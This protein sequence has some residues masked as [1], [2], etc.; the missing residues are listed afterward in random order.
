MQKKNLFV[1]LKED[2]GARAIALTVTIML[3]V[4][5]AIIVTT[6]VAN[7]AANNDNLPPDD[8]QQAGVNDPNTDENPNGTP[9]QTPDETPGDSTQKPDDSQTGTDALPERFLLPVSGVMQQ[10]HDSALQVFSPTMG[11]Y[12]VHLGID[13]GTVEGASVSAMADGTIAQVWEDV[14]M[15]QC[16]AVKHGGDAYTVYKNLSVE[17]PETTVV[18][19]T[20]KA[21]DVIGT[22]GDTAMVEIAE[23]PHLH[24]EMTV[25]G[26]QVN[27]LDYLDEEAKATLNEDVNYEDVS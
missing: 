14:L 4:L 12:R 8:S 7:R 5:T 3:L 20:V 27:P 1:K 24:L 18:G 11:D 15:G 10:K 25:G 23:E 19:A 2:K 26:L 6:V 21:G 16:V 13:I 22:V 17:L 9:D